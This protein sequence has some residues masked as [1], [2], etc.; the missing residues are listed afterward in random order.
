MEKKKSPNPA[1]PRLTRKQKK[2]F[3]LLP[4]CNYDLPSAMDLSRIRPALMERWFRSPHFLQ[5]L[6]NHYLMLEYATSL[7]NMHALQINTHELGILFTRGVDHSL[8]LRACSNLLR[9]HEHT[10]N[11]TRDLFRNCDP[12]DSKDLKRLEEEKK[13]PKQSADNPSLSP[14]CEPHLE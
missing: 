10:R 8:S 9:F 5:M 14:P 7:K 11:F 4:Q 13:Q 12:F 1:G 6:R 2:F 3:D